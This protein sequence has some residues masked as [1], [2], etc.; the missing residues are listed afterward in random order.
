MSEATR[1]TPEEWGEHPGNPRRRLPRIRVYGGKG[2]AW[3]PRQ[4]R[5]ASGW[6]GSESRSDTEQN[7][8]Q[9]TEATGTEPLD[10]D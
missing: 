5:L 6:E 1:C 4:V 3:G 2:H 7:A 10:E 9:L 8:M